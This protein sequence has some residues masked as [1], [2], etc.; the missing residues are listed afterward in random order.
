M[1]RPRIEITDKM[2]SQIETLSG[3]GLTLAQIGAVIGIS[4]RLLCQRR[5]N[6]TTISAALERGRAKAQ[7]VIGKSLFERARDGDVAAIRWWEMTRA[8]RTAEARINQSIEAKVVTA[9]APDWTAL[10]G[11]P[12]A[13]ADEGGDAS[14]G[15]GAVFDQL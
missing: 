6:E 3:Y 4:E 7:G 15:P 1:A 12:I 10:L 13:R 9:K 2:I 8:G 11:Q 5:D 14:S